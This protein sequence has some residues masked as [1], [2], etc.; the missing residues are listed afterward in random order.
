MRYESSFVEHDDVSELTVLVWEAE[1]ESAVPKSNRIRV[2]RERT[3]HRCRRESPE[4][5]LCLCP[6][7][8]FLR[9]RRLCQM[10]T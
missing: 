5:L 6:L 4:S 1:S 10:P 9:F 8:I 7:L 2:L 3:H